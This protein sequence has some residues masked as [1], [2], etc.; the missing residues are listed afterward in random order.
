[1]SVT[2]DEV[3]NNVQEF[4]STA[5]YRA[6]LIYRE[7]AAGRRDP[8]LCEVQYEKY[9]EVAITLSCCFELS[10]K[11]LVAYLAENI[12]ADVTFKDYTDSDKNPL[13]LIERDQFFKEF[14]M[15]DEDD[16]EFEIYGVYNFIKDAVE[17]T[18][19]GK[20]TA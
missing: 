6:F 16:E 18:L 11:K 4:L 5:V 10:L 20:A 12:G 2:F 14:E 3:K 8:K 17:T 15:N 19:K 1:M 13:N 7:I 9:I